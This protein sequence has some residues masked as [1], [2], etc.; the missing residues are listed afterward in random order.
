MRLEIVVDAAPLH[1]LVEVGPWHLHY[2]PRDR[3]GW[4]SYRSLMLGWRVRVGQA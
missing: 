2:F 3:V 4:W 1:V